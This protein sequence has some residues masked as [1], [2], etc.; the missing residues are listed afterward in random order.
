MSLLAHFGAKRTPLLSTCPIQE[1]RDGTFFDGLTAISGTPS[2]FVMHPPLGD[3]GPTIELPADAWWNQFVIGFGNGIN[4]SR[5]IIALTA[6]NKDGGAH[7]DADLP[8]DY[9]ALVQG[10]WLSISPRGQFLISDHHFIYL[11]QM[12]YEILHS[13]QL[14]ALAA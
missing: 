1:I 4:L 14:V 13:L 3:P 5:A 2:G 9:K 7:V 8:E 11:R 10:V 12:G 6:A